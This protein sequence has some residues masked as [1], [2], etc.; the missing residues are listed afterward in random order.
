LIKLNYMNFEEYKDSLQHEK[1]APIPQ[2]ELNQMVLSGG[3][4]DR[5]VMSCQRLVI[6][7]ISKMVIYQKVDDSILFEYV[8]VCNLTILEAAEKY[9]HDKIDFA[10]YIYINM[11]NAIKS[12]HKY[13]HVVKPRV[14][15][16]DRKF[17]SYLHIDAPLSEDGDSFDVE[18]KNEYKVPQINYDLIYKEIKK[19]HKHF[20]KRY[21]DIYLEWL[22]GNKI[23]E[24]GEMYDLTPT[25]VGQII[26]QVTGL[27]K[28]NEKIKKYLSQFCDF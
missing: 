28:E 14:V 10:Y 25:R 26:Q 7:A 1:Y 12:Y 18:D 23:Y 24:I 3:S 16:G 20:K 15:D 27:M 21:M 9:K 11:M 19:D 6:K 8:Q 5:I 4:V 17:P 13:D 22:N 2:K